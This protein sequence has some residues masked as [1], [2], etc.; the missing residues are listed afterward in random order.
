ME[1]DRI[2]F[3]LGMMNCFT[4]MVAVG[5][6][7]LAL[8]PPLTPRDYEAVAGASQKMVE[9][10]GIQ[11]HL[12]KSLLVTDLQSADFTKGKWSILYFKTGDVLNDYLALKARKQELENENRS[13][14]A[15]RREISIQFMKL[16]SY[17]D[18][19][20]QAKLSGKTADPF[21]LVEI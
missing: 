4:E 3:L 8:S 20:I 21:I 14:A 19:V 11:S 16:L 10:F 9:A 13:D 18:D 5:V 6:K 15:G 7:K 2:S 17:P 12:E 1:I